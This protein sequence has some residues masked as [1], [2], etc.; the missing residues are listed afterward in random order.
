MVRSDRQMSDQDTRE[1][2]RRQCVAH[3][4]TCDA[5]GWPYVVPLMYVYQDGDLLYLHTGP[6]QGHFLANIRENPRIC[7]QVNE[8]GTMQRGQPSPCNSALVY[9]SAIAYGT[10]RVVDGPSVNQQ[11]TWF[12]DG[13]L[14]R[15][16]EPMSVYQQPGYPMLDRIILY[17]V[18]LEII[19][20]KLN[21]GLHH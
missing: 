17:E 3:V 1:F 20:G 11:K 4:G 10:V 12:L 5:A 19:T 6:H 8:T 14:E 21:V 16:N 15:L 7:I 9:K 13:L 18:A 2:L